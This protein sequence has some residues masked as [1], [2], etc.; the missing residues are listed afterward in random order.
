[1]PARSIRFELPVRVEGWF[2]VSGGDHELR[3]GGD[4][5]RP[6]ASAEGEY[7]VPRA[8]CRHRGT[9]SWLPILT[10]AAALSSATAAQYARL[11]HWQRFSLLERHPA[12]SWVLLLLVLGQ[13]SLLAH[14]AA[15]DRRYRVVIVT[16]LIGLGLLYHRV[17]GQLPA[18]E[19]YAGR[20]L[21]M[22][23]LWVFLGSWFAGRYFGAGRGCPWRSRGQFELR[24]MMFWT[25]VAGM[26]AATVG[27]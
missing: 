22:W 25:T 24:D 6:N 19:R 21:L 7:A 9:A 18:T 14:I 26:L 1:M 23:S 8:F 10:A 17:L 12:G 20:F 13:L 5:V 27:G 11:A 3:R 4:R 2:V 15:R 16:F